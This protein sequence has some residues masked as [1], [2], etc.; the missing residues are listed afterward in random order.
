[1]AD[2]SVRLVHAADIHLDSPL[3]G[4]GRLDDP[5]LASEMRLATRRAFDKLV[6]HCLKTEPDLLVIAGDLYDGEWR[7]YSTGAYF[8]DRMR[9]LDDAAIPVVIVSGNHD[10]E[11]VI[12]RSLTLPPN[13]SLLSTAQPE[14]VHFD[15]LGL[16]VHGQGFATK[17]VTANLAADY[18]SPVPGIVNVGV[19]HTSVEGYE[20]H[21]PY[22]PCTLADLTGRAYEYF[23]LG[24]VH[25]RQVLTDGAQTVAFSGNLQGRHPRETGP[26]GVLDVRLAPGE[27]ARTDFVALDVAR[28]ANVDVDVTEA[29]DDS[30]LFELVDRRIG[31]AREH[32][33]GRPLVVRVRLTGTSALASTLTDTSR[34]GFEIRPRA[35]RHGVAVDTITSEVETPVGRRALPASQRT[36]FEDVL[37][38]ATASPTTL[39]ADPSVKPD[40]DA[41]TSEVNERYLR[42]TGLDLREAG[43]LAAAVT[44][45]AR[46]LQA[47]ADGGLL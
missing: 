31:L 11:S 10:A 28:W 32:A 5:D 15:D 16:A 23:A 34:V 25:H 36:V 17:S 40:L 18:P 7:D 37:R 45:A 1:M 33:E 44:T 8:C 38:Q 14:T 35:A 29:E 46:R 19:L 43:Q 21:D 26:K 24:H 30:T 6:G 12:T 22:A 9:D 27:P 42:E 47:M 39:L 2:D 13:V 4:L 41:L 20:G 3:R